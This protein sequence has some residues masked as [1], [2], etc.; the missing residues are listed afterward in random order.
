MNEE[1]KAERRERK[2][3]KRMPIHGHSIAE[4]YR[5]AIEKRMNNGN[6]HSKTKRNK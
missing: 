4:A 2:N 3:R 1:T 5:N 6:R